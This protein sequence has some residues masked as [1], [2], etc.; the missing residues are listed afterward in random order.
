[1]PPSVVV[2]KDRAV[3]LRTA[4]CDRAGREGRPREP[5]FEARARAKEK[6]DEFERVLQSEGRSFLFANHAHHSL[7]RPKPIA[8]KVN[9]R[10]PAPNSNSKMTHLQTLKSR[11]VESFNAEP[12]YLLCDRT[13]ELQYD[14]LAESALR[15]NAGSQAVTKR[16][17]TQGASLQTP[18]INSR[19]IGMAAAAQCANAQLTLGLAE[20]R[21]RDSG[22]RVV[23][24]LGTTCVSP[25]RL[26]FLSEEQRARL[27][28]ADPETT[29]LPV[30]T[31][32][33][34]LYN[35]CPVKMGT[36]CIRSAAN[37]IA[38]RELSENLVSGALYYD[39]MITSICKSVGGGYEI[40]AIWAAVVLIVFLTFD[41]RGRRI[42]AETK[43]TDVDLQIA[44]TLETYGK[45]EITHR[46]HLLQQ[47]QRDA[48][49]EQA[50]SRKRRAD[51]EE[52]EEKK[53]EKG[54]DDDDDET[55]EAASA[56]SSSSSS[57]PASVPCP[58]GA[59]VEETENDEMRML[60]SKRRRTG[61]STHR[62]ACA[63]T[64]ES[65]ALLSWWFHALRSKQSSVLETLIA[66]SRDTAKEAATTSLRRQAGDDQLLLSNK[67]LSGISISTAVKSCEELVRLVHRSLRHIPVVVSAR[68]A[69]TRD[70]VVVGINRMPN[71]VAPVALHACS[72]ADESLQP[73]ASTG[74]LFLHSAAVQDVAQRS[75]AMGVAERYAKMGEVRG[76]DPA[77]SAS[78]K[79]QQTLSRLQSFVDHE[80]MRPLISI[81]AGVT[82]SFASIRMTVPVSASMRRS[83]ENLRAE[84]AALATTSA[85]SD[86]HAS[87][88][89][90][91]C[92]LSTS[93]DDQSR[94]EPVCAPTSRLGVGL[95]LNEL[96]RRY[97][98]G[99]TRK[100]GISVVVC[101]LRAEKASDDI[102]KD[103][104]SIMDTEPLPMAIV[105]DV[106]FHCKREHVRDST[107][108]VG[109]SLTLCV[110]SATRVAELV[111]RMD[112]VF[113][114]RALMLTASSQASYIGD[115]GS[116]LSAQWA[117]C[118]SASSKKVSCADVNTLPLL[119]VWDCVVG[120]LVNVHRNYSNTAY[121]G[122][123]GPQV[124]IGITSPG[125]LGSY[126]RADKR[127]HG[128]VS[129]SQAAS[130]RLCDLITESH[131]V[132]VGDS[133][134][135]TTPI[136]TRGIPHGAVPGLH[137][138]LNAYDAGLE[139]CRKLTNREDDP[140]V[141]GVFVLPFSAFTQALAP[142]V[143]CTADPTIRHVFREPAQSSAATGRSYLSDTTSEEEAIFVEPLWRR[144]CQVTS[145]DNPF[146]TSY[147][148]ADSV[149]N[150]MSH[151]SLLVL[152]VGRR[153]ANGDAERGV[154]ELL[155]DFHSLV[156]RAVFEDEQSDASIWV[157]DFLV[158]VFG[159]VYPA[160]YLVNEK[161]VPRC[162]S[163][164]ASRMGKKCMAQK[165]KGDA[166]VGDRFSRLVTADQ[167][168]D[169]RR[170][171]SKC[172]TRPSESCVWARGLRPLLRLLMLQQG[173][174]VVEAH[175]VRQ[176][177][178]AVDGLA[179]AAWLFH[180]DD[181]V[182]PPLDAANPL[183]GC[184]SPAH[185]SRLHVDP[186]FVAKGDD[187]EIDPRGCIVGLLPFQLRQLYIL[188][189]GTHLRNAKPQVVRNEGGLNL[190]L[191]SAADVLQ[192]TG[193]PRSDKAVS[194][195]Q[196]EA[197]S[198]TFGCR[199]AKVYGAS[200]QR[201]AWDRNALLL[202]PVL[203]RIEAPRSERWRARGEWGDASWLHR[204]LQIQQDSN[205]PASDVEKFA[206]NRL[207]S[208]GLQSVSAFRW[209]HDV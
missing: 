98:I 179:R 133:H 80:T 101:G 135:T 127:K 99:R 100:N 39:P 197:D 190:R 120:G 29:F 58:L 97:M 71:K 42:L 126:Y 10:S 55:T 32:T 166:V 162:L 5:S 178:T 128:T 64:S 192:R 173:G 181:G 200:L 196:I 199:E 134:Y 186:V 96:L 164:L 184:A 63:S 103:L 130:D 77:S 9:T 76:L 26:C 136:Q 49:A 13:A 191:S 156:T 153:R 83:A 125:L 86:S 40:D 25:S 11:T 172:A 60:G 148:Y 209:L 1:M 22:L 20:M 27:L 70:E 8:Y 6:V 146:S 163:L 52:K 122:T 171:W 208:A 7:P 73:H 168:E 157:V 51:E 151:I 82:R 111:G 161:T 108:T 185:M 81:H 102:P 17:A 37:E 68:T 140:V 75:V 167:L 53:E 48:Q 193:E 207:E 19:S 94:T 183:H 152:D 36:S 195:L 38:R 202:A 145:E 57:S 79:T 84:A 87:A 35:A 131:Y 89:S 65:Y 165:S 203:N 47:Q 43:L 188:L 175:T 16:R 34:L 109:A 74:I 187:L 176:F 4:K 117:N 44:F 88:V 121:S 142:D 93:Q 21:M 56:S 59:L 12:G 169:V 23:N 33:E 115:V 112:D 129:L 198:A 66:S 170:L 201:E 174:H 95:R 62:S 46:V 105:S 150:A 158:L 114:R 182:T 107:A 147:P 3:A 180:S 204:Y 69:W 85:A 137:S 78:A 31:T 160:S 138:V 118:S 141:D 104:G 90:P 154:D 132:R 110:D 144:P 124:C 91:L 14:R 177:R 113:E 15:A 155:D 194:P 50:S 206:R 149:F 30:V 123:Y 45:A 143:E 189:Q 41:P 67:T 28:S 92:V 61:K 54:E 18:R 205:K 159:C 119:S 2:I 139:T 24:P 116:A 106:S 72:L